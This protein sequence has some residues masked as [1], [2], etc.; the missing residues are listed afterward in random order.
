MIHICIPFNF[1]HLWQLILPEF[2]WDEAFSNIANKI[3]GTK[4][5]RV[6]F[7]I[8]LEYL[9]QIIVKIKKN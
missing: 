1:L 8:H 5:V 6:N 3:R 9:L 2:F 7:K 4:K